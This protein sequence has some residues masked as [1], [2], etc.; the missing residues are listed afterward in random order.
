VC[1][2][3]LGSLGITGLKYLELTRGS[4]K[5]RIR[6]PGEEI[7]AGHSLMDDLS[8]QAG[9]IAGQVSEAL[10]KINHLIGPDTK[11]RMDSI[12]D[13]TDQLLATAN[14]TLEENRE[15]L[16]LLME[17]LNQ[18]A[19]RGD[20]ALALLMGS[21]ER[22]DGTFAK[23][24]PLLLKTLRRVAT[25]SADLRR[26]RGYLDE[27]LINARDLLKELQGLLEPSKESLKSAQSTLKQVKRFMSR[28][29]EDFAEALSFLKET[30][31]NMSLFSERIK[32]DPSL[33]LL[34]EDEREPR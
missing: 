24:E 23:A 4:R 7:P 11:V 16:R 27:A 34:G 30:A 15:G 8:K 10:G 31:E 29:R 9:Q 14:A 22:L 3:N 12:L 6:A 19:A 26:S 25:L 32:D 1:R 18:L 20:G 13:R 21:L 17:H 28:S 5:A 33:L 2:A